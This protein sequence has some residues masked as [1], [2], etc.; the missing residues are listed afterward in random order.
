MS[1]LIHDFD[2]FTILAIPQSVHHKIPSTGFFQRYQ[3]KGPDIVPALSEP[4]RRIP[5]QLAFRV[6]DNHTFAPALAA[7]DFVSHNRSGFH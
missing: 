3:V 4:G 5:E 7:D 1:H 2:F 6:G